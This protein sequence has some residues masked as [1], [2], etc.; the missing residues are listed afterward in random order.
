MPWCRAPATRE[1]DVVAI[2]AWLLDSL[3][4]A[5]QRERVAAIVPIAHGAAAVLVDHAG[6][7]ARRAGLRG[8]LLR[9]GGARN[10]RRCAIPSR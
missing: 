2:E 10:T 7:G 4:S 1:L 9:R 3:R 5:P 8:H 6:D